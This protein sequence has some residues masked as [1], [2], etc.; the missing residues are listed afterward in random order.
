MRVLG[1]I[2]GTSHDG[3]DAAVVELTH[4]AD[5]LRMRVVGTDSVPYAAALRAR[6]VA[7]LPP[8]PSTVDEL[9]ELDTLIGQAFAEVAVT[10]AD[11]HGPLD[12]ICSHGQTVFHWVERG[13]ALGSLQLGQPAWI[14]ERTGVPVVADVRLRDITAGGQGAPLVPILDELLLADA[15]E[16]AA[17]LNLGGIANVTVVRPGW[18]SIAYDIGPANAL[19]DAVV[20]DRELDPHG[21]DTDG[22]LA[23]AG[24]VDSAL[25]QHLLADPYYAEPAPKSTGKEH[26]H[27]AYVRE[28]VGDRQLSDAD[29]VA[30]LTRLTAETVG[31][32]LAGLGVRRVVAA[33]G[34]TA[35]PLLM[36]WLAEVAA[37]VEI[38]TT[39]ALGIPADAKEAIA[40][41]LIG[42]CSW[43]GLP[44]NVPSATGAEAPRVLGALIPGKEPLRL[45]EPLESLPGLVIE[46]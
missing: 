39:D 35:N 27:L 13:R 19:V 9:T 45:P 43:H 37:G 44:G 8:A 3:I 40:F 10:M 46:R 6:L 11:R 34:G 2:S 17:A 20:Q 33:G 16:P 28:Q 26:F 22:R 1:L 21:Y 42:W 29:L 23:A 5:V 15:D 4:S 18:P 12:L 7:A 30:T 38:V 36:G 14:A 41:A 25:L 32:D 24:T 31:R